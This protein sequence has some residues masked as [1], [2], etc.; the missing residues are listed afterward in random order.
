MNPVAAAGFGSA[1]DVYERARPSYPEAAVS[2]L[3]ERAGLDYG[4]TVVDVGA[5][6]GKLTRLLASTHARV[7][8]VEPVEAMRDVLLDRVPG[9]EVLAGTAEALPLPD[10]TADAV[11]CAQ[12]F[13]WFANETAIAELHRVLKPEGALVLIWNSRD[14]SDPLQRALEDLLGSLR[15]GVIGQLE[16][17]WRDAIEGSALFGPLEEARFELKQTLTPEGVCDRV[18]STSFVA[19]MPAAERE[20]LLARVRELVGTRDEPVAFPYVTEVYVTRSRLRTR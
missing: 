5:G 17:A 2:W 7:I 6:T 18:A 19:A 9:V 16:G 4:T 8:A 10:A 13:H 12:S 1:A 3:A 20:A 14:M 11:T 15:E